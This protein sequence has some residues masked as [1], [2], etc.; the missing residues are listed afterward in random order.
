MLVPSIDAFTI[1][2]AR[3]A[4]DAARATNGR[5]V[6]DEAVAAPGTASLCL[7][8]IFATFVMSTL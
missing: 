6:S 4:S 3:S 2:N 1:G 7:S 5:Y 8:R